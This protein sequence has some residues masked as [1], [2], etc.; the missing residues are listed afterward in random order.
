MYFYLGEYPK[1]HPRIILDNFDIID[2][3]NHPYDGLIK[4]SVLPPRKLYHPILPF[5]AG[6]KTMFPL[7]ATCALTKQKSKCKHSNKERTLH[8]EW[9]ST[10]LYAA[11]KEGYIV[12]RII[13]YINLDFSKYKF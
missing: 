10:E 13:A 5:R 12:R 6:G 7:C 1:G 8:G 9:I 4:C 11:V 2:K 3:D